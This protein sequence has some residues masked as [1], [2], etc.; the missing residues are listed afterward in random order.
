MR[1]CVL[2]T[3]RAACV[4]P[5]CFLLDAYASLF[6]TM[7]GQYFLL[8]LPLVLDICTAA[9]AG[10]EQTGDDKVTFLKTLPL[11]EFVTF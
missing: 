5:T 2:E 8:F 1:P 3:L 4:Q 6:Q 11:A 7:V 9:D 10:I